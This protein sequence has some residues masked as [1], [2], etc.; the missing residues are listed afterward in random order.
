MSTHK[1][2]QSII[3]YIET[4]KEEEITLKESNKIIELLDNVAQPSEEERRSIELVLNSLKCN[5]EAQEN[6]TKYIRTS[7]YEIING[8]KYDRSLLLKADNLVKGQGDGRISEEDMKTLIIES[9]DNNKITEIEKQT[10]FY[11]SETYNTTE[12]SK[13]YLNSYFN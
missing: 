12:K 8:I 1:L 2:K 3:D 9:A 11:I 13:E 10:L 7:Y 6:L 4:I 5:N